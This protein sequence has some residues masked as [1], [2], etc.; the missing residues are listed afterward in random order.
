M[1]NFLIHLLDHEES[2]IEREYR[3]RIYV[4]LAKLQKNRFFVK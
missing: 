1:S 4:L 2:L 3:V